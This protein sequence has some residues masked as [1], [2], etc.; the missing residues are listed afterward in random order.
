MPYELL[1]LD[2]CCAPLDEIKAALRRRILEHGLEDDILEASVPRPFQQLA[3]QM[4]AAY[5]N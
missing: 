1:A 2:W 4:R 5:S 3:R